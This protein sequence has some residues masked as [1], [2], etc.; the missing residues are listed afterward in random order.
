M[1]LADDLKTS[2][3]SGPVSTIQN[4]LLQSAVLEKESPYGSIDSLDAAMSL[5]RGACTRACTYGASGNELV[6]R[7]LR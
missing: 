4:C 5:S 6:V 1:M 2:R 3:V 7:K